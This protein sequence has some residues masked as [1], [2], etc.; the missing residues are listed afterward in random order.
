MTIAS[1]IAI[2]V[3]IFASTNIDDIFVLV[4]FF[5]DPKLGRWHIVAGQFFGIGLIVAASMAAA[6]VALAVSAP[7]VG[8]LGFAPI[9]IGVKKMWDLWR[10]GGVESELKNHPRGA[11]E[12]GGHFAVAAVTIANSGDN[13]GVYVPL[14]A[15]QQVWEML[16]TITVF[17]MMTLAWCL[18]AW[19]L[20][21]HPTLGKPARLYGCRVLPFIL[22]GLGGLILYTSGATD[23]LLGLVRK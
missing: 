9:A 1:L 3:V 7:Y 20:V 4:G 5:S 14:F 21:K 18:A 6:L 13:L 16:V 15:T 19:R 2:S 8:F 17:A 12:H 11:C 10:R 22:M 23:L